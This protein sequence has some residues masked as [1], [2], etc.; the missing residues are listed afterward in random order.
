MKRSLANKH[1]TKPEDL[2]AAITDFLEEVPP[3]TW[4]GVF[5]AWMERVRWVINNDGDCFH[6]ETH[7]SEKLFLIPVP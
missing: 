1:F 6:R 5:D 3:R 4:I 7:S 2:L